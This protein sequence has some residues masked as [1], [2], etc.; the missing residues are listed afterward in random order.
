M[1][2]PKDEKH[3]R[4]FLTSCSREEEEVERYH[5]PSALRVM[6]SRVN[7]GS[8]PY[9]GRGLENVTQETL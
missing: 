1:M 6:I 5:L 8:S 2:E 4:V 7:D 9:S 3:Q